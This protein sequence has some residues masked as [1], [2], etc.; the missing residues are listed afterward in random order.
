MA[1]EPGRVVPAVS[2]VAC[3]TC[4]ERDGSDDRTMT[5]EP[6]PAPTGGRHADRSGGDARPGRGADTSPGDGSPGDGSPGARFRRWVV[7][8]LDVLARVARS[9]TGNPTEAEDLVQDTLLRAYRAIDRFD[10]RH[11]R[12]WLLTILRNAHV[13]RNRRRRPTLLRDPDTTMEQLAAPPSA[14]DPEDAAVR[15]TFS[16]AVEEAF[17]DLPPRFRRV[18]ELVDVGGLSYAEAAAVLGVPIGTVMSRLHRG[19]RRIRARL[20][21]AGIRPPGTARDGAD[22]TTGPGPASGPT[23]D[24][25]PS[26][27]DTA[28]EAP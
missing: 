6:R 12:A 2:L 16:A 20:A 14:D 5:G 15:D 13:N 22:G 24:P 25:R 9:I 4:E 26:T 28:R 21:A 7:P 3:P 8:E 27:D 11:P 10:G 23:P 17:A 19:R 18:V 1:A